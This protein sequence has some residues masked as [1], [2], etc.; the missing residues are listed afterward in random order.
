MN[1]SMVIL[2]V[3]DTGIGISE[4]NIKK[5]YDPFFSTKSTGKGTGLGL[6]VS[7]G[8]VQE[9]GGRIFVDSIPG[10]GSHFRLK[11]PTRHLDRY[12]P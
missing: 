11:L 2:D 10:S 3:R 1:E 6:A 5:I 8:I 7:Y 9:H 4:E 12:E